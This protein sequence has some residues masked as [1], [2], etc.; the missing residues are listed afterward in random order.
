MNLIRL[1]LYT[2][3]QD[4]VH[5]Q[6]CLWAF[7]TAISACV[8][9]NV[10]VEQ[11]AGRPLYPNLFTLL[12][13]PPGCGKGTAIDA[14]TPLVEGFPGVNIYK[15]PMNGPSLFMTLHQCKNRIDPTSGERIGSKIFLVMEELAMDAGT[16]KE[17]EQFI[18]YMTGMWKP[19]PGKFE[20]TTVTSKRY[21]LR[22]TCIN[23]LGGT[24]RHWIFDVLSAKDFQAGSGR[25]IAVIEGYIDPDKRHTHVK[26]PPDRDEVLEHIRMRLEHLTQLRGVR[27]TKTP[28]ALAWED[29]WYRTRPP[30]KTE[31]DI[32]RWR[33][34]PELMNQLAIGLV[35]ADGG[36]FVMNTKHLHQAWKLTQ[37]AQEG[38]P[39]I[40]AASKSQDASLLND[41]YVVIRDHPGVTWAELVEKSGLMAWRLRGVTTTLIQGGKVYSFK[42]TNGVTRFGTD[43]VLKM[44][45][46]PTIFEMPVEE[47]LKLAKQ[48]SAP[49][50]LDPEP[51]QEPD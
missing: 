4:E 12:V 19:I 1:F 24:T 8:R 37:D 41:V 5:D 15:G 40:I 25:R 26:L 33:Q 45:N 18:K 36:N 39:R 9:D 17:A 6:F 7:L 43:D 34:E 47:A 27:I 3:G 20:K 13:G 32:A 35:L 38:L 48:L 44:K 22:D 49:K 29:Y 23:F 50:I 2:R 46:A 10:T 16:G 42:D 51:E 11:L 21:Q 28:A 30:Y 14:V 31:D